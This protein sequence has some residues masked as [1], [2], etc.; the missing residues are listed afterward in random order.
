M[1]NAFISYSH[2]ADGKLAP[3]LV[4]ALE[5]FA[6]PWYKLRN[7]NIFRDETSLSASPHLW[8]NITA[9][10]DQSQYLIYMAS[11]ESAQSKWVTLEI[12]YWLEHNSIDS[13]IIV[14]TDGEIQWD[15]KKEISLSVQN[16]SLPQILESKLTAEPFFIDLRSAKTADD[17]IINNPIFKKEVLKLAAQLHGREPKDLASEEVRAHKRMLWIRNGAITILLLFLMI[18][19]YQTFEAKRQT[20]IANEQTQS[21][22]ESNSNAQNQRRIAEEHSKIAELERQRAKDS[23]EVAQNQRQIAIIERDNARRQEDIAI[24]EK[25]QAQANYLISEAKSQIKKD[26]TLALQLAIAA[27]RLK[28]N[29]EVI[30]NSLATI[31]R[32]FIPY[33]TFNHRS[34][35]GNALYTP[36][37]D[38]I[39][40]SSEN[41]IT[42][43]DNMGNMID[44][45]DVSSHVLSIAIS[46]DGTRILTG[47]SDNT[48]RLWKL[49]GTLVQEFEGHIDKVSSVAF[50]PDGSKIL[51]G[52]Y[53]THMFKQD[54][55]PI[56]TAF[57]FGKVTNMIF[58]PDG[59]QILITDYGNDARLW[60]I[61]G[62]LI[63]KFEGHNG[64]IFAIAFSPNGNQ[65]LTGSYDQTVRLWP[66]ESGEPQIYYATDWVRSVA[67]SPD[68]NQ[69]VF[70]SD[71]VVELIDLIGGNSNTLSGHSDKVSSVAFSPDGKQVLTGSFDKTAR[72]WDLSEG[73]LMHEFELRDKYRNLV[74]FSM[75]GS[76]IITQ[77]EN[78]RPFK[79]DNLSLQY[80]NLKGQKVQRLKDDSADTSELVYLPGS[81]IQT[82]LNSPNLTAIDISSNKKLILTGNS[83]GN[84]FIWD[85]SGR[86][87]R[88][89]S[90]HSGE[91]HT[92]KFSSNGALI[93]TGEYNG[94][95]R[96]SDLHGN[97]KE[98]SFGNRV[99]DAVLFVSFSP[100]G[101]TIL[102]GSRGGIAGLF[103]LKGKL[104]RKFTFYE[105]GG[106]QNMKP[107]SYSPVMFS[108]NGKLILTGSQN[109]TMYLWDLEGHILHQYIGH[110]AFINSAAFS[111]DGSLL[112]SVSVNGIVRLWRAHLALD[113]F[114][115]NQSIAPLTSAQKELYG[116]E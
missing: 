55:S 90:G 5:K 97:G 94:P 11:P 9:A 66:I 105:G 98:I 15:E 64:Q 25:I 4:T 92:V 74:S 113:D 89:F 73:T 40:T 22:K 80:W 83:K 29:S 6:K 77:L 26:Q 63:R 54:G 13:L 48:V 85:Y 27:S 69:I 112:V 58:S 3:A 24:S 71:K 70:S 49:D 84:V 96:I 93:L 42:I 79:N 106:A 57:E 51:T 28:P 67:F 33:K 60:A 32:N 50:S 23:S 38:K 45:F 7:L 19:I 59:S 37:G 99:D 103:D 110:K 91:I 101:K 61:D 35:L 41:T 36:M 53:H 14:L 1:Y 56:P 116:I 20:K 115:E 52:A 34:Y 65:I 78:H 18:S 39:I 100:D 62:T 82:Y 75:D 76:Q 87:L 21:A 88:N 12:E 81:E 47:L 95:A 107:I 86:K 43:W 104:I 111:P 16:N 2:A 108:P 68:G 102:A 30:K 44:E 109:N 31:Y 72:I 46:P 17:I 8:S 114:L 10:L